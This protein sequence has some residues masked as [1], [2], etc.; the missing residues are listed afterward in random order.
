MDFNDFLAEFDEVYACRNY[1]KENG[2]A[3]LQIAD[4][5]TGGYA[6]G[7]P[8]GGNRGAKMEKNPQ[9][10]ITINKPGKGFFVLRL[11]ERSE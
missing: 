9:Y 4:Q 3:N 7:L 2:W 6:E 11:V 8:H 1:T 10:G 5:W